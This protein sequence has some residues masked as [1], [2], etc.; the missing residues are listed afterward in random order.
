MKKIVLTAIVMIL[1][2]FGMVSLDGLPVLATEDGGEGTTVNTSILDGSKVGK[3]GEGIF[4]ILNIVLTIMTFGVGILATIGIV[5]AGYVYL[6]AKDD[7]SKIQ[8]AKERL[9]QIV[10]GMGLYAMLW[11]LLQFLLPGGLFGGN[12]G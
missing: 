10:I 2:A 3:N 5:I 12:G 8:K 4:Y 7:A 9:I 1:V 6:T 11:T